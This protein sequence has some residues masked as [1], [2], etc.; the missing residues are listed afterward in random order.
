MRIGSRG[1][2]VT[3]G[4]SGWRLLLSLS[5]TALLV[6]SQASAAN[7]VGEL[8]R[9]RG[10]AACISTTGSAGACEDGGIIGGGKATISPD[11]RNFYVTSYTSSTVVVFDRDPQTG[12][13]RQKRGKAAC[14]SAD[15][16]EIPG[17][18]G[19]ARG[20]AFE[21]VEALAISPDGGTVYVVSEHFDAVAIFD[22]NRATGALAQ[23]SGKA[24]C[25]SAGGAKDGCEKARAIKSPT[26]LTISPDG[27]NLY[28]SSLGTPAVAVFDVDPATGRLTQEP[29]AA[30]CV[31][32]DAAEVGCGEARSLAGSF[33]LTLSPDG[34]SLYVTSYEQP[35]LGSGRIGPSSLLIFDRDPATGSVTQKA[36]PDGCIESRATAA[37]CRVDPVLQGAEA[38]A[39]S[40]D[41]RSAYVAADDAG[42][43]SIF[44]RDPSGALVK[45][46][47]PAGCV[48]S[49]GTS[50]GCA[51]G[52]TFSGPNG[53]AVSP[54][55]SSVYVTSRGVR[56]FGDLD[57][58]DGEEPPNTASLTVFDRDPTTGALRQ[59]PVARGC[60]SASRTKSC[61]TAKG[62]ATPGDLI[63]SSDGKNVYVVGH[64]PGTV[65]TFDRALR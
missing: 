53:V 8:S 7:A 28:V 6:L 29:G 49:D 20:H 58:H 22:R 45:K 51:E 46:E 5:A 19:C 1:T 14:I 4:R 12:A 60:I 30:G 34:K 56:G 55:G 13:L 65:S 61:G 40:P 47:G 50:G 16:G 18:A 25:I 21:E 15:P 17:T 52:R 44:D 33:Q 59:K 64:H 2:T 37:G 10:P 9:A 36:G 62:L 24:G 42:M 11:G 23:R 43:L 63:A 32:R 57:P 27:R 3:A 31:S 26:D 54:D 41:G 48:S 35:P 38:V 39:V